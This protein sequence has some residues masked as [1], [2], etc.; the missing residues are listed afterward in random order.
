MP[1][2]SKD[3]MYNLF[4]KDVAFSK[5]PSYTHAVTILVVLLHMS[6]F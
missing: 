3:L 5:V 4:C 6:M 2:V 1:G